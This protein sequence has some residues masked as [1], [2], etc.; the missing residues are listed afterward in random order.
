MLEN[1]PDGYSFYL[2][3]LSPFQ[4]W[5]LDNDEIFCDSSSQ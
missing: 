3:G 4:N 5:A 1:R 2:Y